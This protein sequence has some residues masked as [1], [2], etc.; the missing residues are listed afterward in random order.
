[1]QRKYVIASVA[2][3]VIVLV[4]AVA[5]ILAFTFRSSPTVIRVEPE[6]VGR[7]AVGD[8]FVVNVTVENC[9][10]VLAV[11]VDLR[12]DPTVLNATN[13]VEGPFLPS[14]RNTMPL[15]NRAANFTDTLPRSA[16]VLVGDSL[17][18]Y[19]NGTDASGNGVLLTI[20]F[21]VVGEGST[22]LQLYPRDTT[23]VNNIEGT[24]FLN[25]NQNT[26][27]PELHNGSYGGSS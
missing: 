27:L 15:I 22:E 9:V 20:T 7:L 8:T 16:G 14:V 23:T 21:R 4:S 19:G 10:N 1:M 6:N 26:I 18:G 3:V 13:I 2:I 25:R 5:A 17:V 12:Y 24:Y 11:Q